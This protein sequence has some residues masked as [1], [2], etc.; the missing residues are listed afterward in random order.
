MGTQ[1]V[2]KVGVTE[3]QTRFRCFDSVH[4][5]PRIDDFMFSIPSTLDSPKLNLEDRR[6][7][8]SFKISAKIFSMSL[9]IQF[10]NQYFEI[11]LWLPRT[12]NPLILGTKIVGRR[13]HGKPRTRLQFQ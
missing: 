8:E 7:C 12:L 3:C 1:L 13:C 5:R 11:V 4:S 9:S 10:L 2:L 6:H